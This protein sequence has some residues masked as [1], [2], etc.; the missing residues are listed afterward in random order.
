MCFSLHSTARQVNLW[1]VLVCLWLCCNKS[2]RWHIS[3]C[4]VL[5]ASQSAIE[6]QL[7]IQ[8]GDYI[9]ANNKNGVVSKNGQNYGWQFFSVENAHRTLREETF[10]VVTT[11]TRIMSVM[12]W[13]LKP[14]R[15]K[16]S[17]LM[18]PQNIE[19]FTCKPFYI[20]KQPNVFICINILGCKEF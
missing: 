7:P 12:F 17:Y 8:R 19:V 6:T 5:Q 10:D 18:L 11:N 13:S 15:V 16:T 1:H 4:F 3:I 2:N 14:T 9:D 20:R